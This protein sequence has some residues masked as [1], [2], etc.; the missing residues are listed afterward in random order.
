[1]IFVRKIDEQGYF[2][3]DDFVEDITEFTI[4]TPVP[5]GFYKPKWNG[6]EWIEGLT[7]SEIDAIK[8]IL[9]PI[10]V[11]AELESDIASATTLEELKSALLG[12]NGLAKV[13]GRIK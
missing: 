9:T 7:Q 4:E 13:K 11:D 5:Q 1:M 10:D 8:N 3:E 2:I 12:K 6:A